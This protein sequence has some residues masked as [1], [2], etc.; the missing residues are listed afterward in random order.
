MLDSLVG[1]AD[2]SLPS[3][4]ADASWA[5]STARSPPSTRSLKIGLEGITVAGLERLR[6]VAVVGEVTGERRY[7]DEGPSSYEPRPLT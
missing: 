6:A 1:T 7:P 5:S 2:G 3:C 4:L